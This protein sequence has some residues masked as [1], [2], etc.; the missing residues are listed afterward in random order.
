MKLCQQ[1]YLSKKTI[2]FTVVEKCS[3]Q[4]GLN[5]II[6][7]LFLIKIRARKPTTG[8]EQHLQQKAA[9]T[10]LVFRQN[11]FWRFGLM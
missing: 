5:L 4:D 2:D 11:P 6:Y 1:R 9:D 3:Y 10:L 8:G 7:N